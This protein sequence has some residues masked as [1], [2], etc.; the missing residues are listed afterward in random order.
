MEHDQGDECVDGLESE[1]DAG[2]ESDLGVD[3]FDP[4]VGQVV[5]EGVGDV[6]LVVADAAGQF[7]ERG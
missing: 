2:K 3:R 1:R 6:V 5:G 4:G 7:D